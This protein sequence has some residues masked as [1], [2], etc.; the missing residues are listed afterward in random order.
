MNATRIE[1]IDASLVANNTVVAD[2]F[3]RPDWKLIEDWIDQNVKDPHVDQAWSEA[4]GCWLESVKA[5][6]GD[7][8]EVYASNRFYLLCA[9]EESVAETLI[10]FAEDA[11]DKI[12][13]Y[14]H[15][16]ELDELCGKN[17]ILAFADQ[18]T[19][20][21]YISYYY[22]EG[23]YGFSGGL[24]IREGYEH[25]V[26]AP[27][28]LWPLENVLTHELTHAVLCA[29]SLPQWL[30]EGLAQIIEE[31]VLNRAT[32]TIDIEAKRRHDDYWRRHGL[33]KFWSGEA[34]GLSDQGQGLSYAL[35]QVLVRNMS[36]DHGDRF[37][38]FVQAAQADDAG[39]AAAREHLKCGL[40]DCVG[41]FLGEGDWAPRAAD[42]P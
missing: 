9:Y 1:H 13:Q 4:G 41:Q 7:Q 8:Y 40:A 11:W 2:G 35:A 12:L 3:P 36:T 24:N 16:L 38:D 15:R 29:L 37:F 23:E 33:Q 22:S 21:T 30:E 18:D 20:Y 26:M 42:W 25:V 32:F 14:L 34:F 17:A 28:E 5:H 27:D 39:E 10:W 19:Y 31:L 6:L